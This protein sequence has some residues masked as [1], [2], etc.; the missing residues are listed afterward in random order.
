MITFPLSAGIFVYANSYD[1]LSLPQVQ[2][3]RSTLRRL[4]ALDL[5]FWC[6][7]DYLG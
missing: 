3:H 4:S 5:W 2:F 7:Q 6:M 1:E